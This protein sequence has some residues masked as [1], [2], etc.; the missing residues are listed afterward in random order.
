M[1]LA[2]SISRLTVYYQR[3]GFA[4]TMRRASLALKRALFS[5][6]TVVFHCDLGTLP[7]APVNTPNLP[8]VERV[9]SYGELSQQDWKDITSFWNPKLADRNIKERFQRGAS[10]WLIR[11][12][13][14]LAGYGWTLKGR[15]MEPYF[16][17]LAPEDVHLFDF[18]VFAQHRGQGLNPALVNHILHDLA[19][20]GRGR[21]FIEAGEWNEAQ[22]SS[23][24]KTPFCRLGMA[25]SFSIFGHTVADWTEK[26]TSGRDSNNGTEKAAAARAG[27]NEE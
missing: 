12:Q 5:S 8:R 11:S 23:L 19:T 18:H 21:A 17:P 6:R 20:T 7:V 13:D 14:R 24:R 4:R 16:F 27:S 10:L 25:K 9:T 22:L 2:N 1:N 3:H 26:E 15:T